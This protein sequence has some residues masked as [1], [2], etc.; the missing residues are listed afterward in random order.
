M[1]TATLFQVQPEGHCEPRNGANLT[2][3]IFWRSNSVIYNL[4]T[5]D[6]NFPE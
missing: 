2:A 1:L 3:V 5:C 6:V 4:F